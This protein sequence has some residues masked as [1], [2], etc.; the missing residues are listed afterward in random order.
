LS[1]SRRILLID[2]TKEIHNALTPYLTK[3]GYECLGT[4]DGL[5]GL[6]QVASFHPDVIIL[7]INMPGMS[8]VEVQT[9]LNRRKIKTPVIMMTG[10]TSMQNA[11][12]TIRAGAYDYITKPFD[13]E[14]I[15]LLLKRCFEE[16]DARRSG[17][18]SLKATLPPGKFELLGSSPAMIDIYKTIGNIANTDPSIN[19]LIHGETGTGKELIARQIHAWGS[20]LKSP[21]VAVNATALPDN[22]VESE[23][24]GF[25][26]GAFTGALQRTAGKL[27]AAEDGT[28]LLDEIGDLSLHLQHKLL[29]VLQEREFYRLGGNDVV[30]LKARVVAATNRNLSELIDSGQFRNDL[31]FRLNVI[32][33]N[34]PPLR[35]RIEDI[36]I[37]AQHLL[38]KHTQLMGRKTP[39]LDISALSALTSYHW[40]GN[41]RELENA[42][43]RALTST[44]THRLTAQ[45]FQLQSKPAAASPA[46]SENIFEADL[47][48]ARRL[49]LENVDKTYIVEAIRRNQGNIQKAA[50]QAGINRVS[51]Y[52]LMRKY[53][54]KP[55]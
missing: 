38:E 53:D 13:L 44:R 22:L 55:K 10:Y 17:Q 9:E 23:L 54:I 3:L 30:Q 34:V 46:S 35:D 19:V 27:E 5:S 4:L 33:I 14:R 21:F 20:R 24:F 48:E 37:L 7:D 52:R 28:L 11:I 50:T 29:R 2:D 42:I 47:T 31:Y 41:I 51:F 12:L 18:A 45:H 25:E 40:P 8:G 26:K 15:R 6:D 39:Q 16:L 32:S 49:A 36:P 1:E 43:L